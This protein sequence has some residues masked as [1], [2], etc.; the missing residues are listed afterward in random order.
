MHRDKLNGNWGSPGE[1]Y[2]KAGNGYRYFLQPLTGIH[3]DP[4]NI[5]FQVTPSGNIKYVYALIF[6]G[7]SYLLLPVSIS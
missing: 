1:D 7:C 3:L 6:I 4:T 2:K 5:E